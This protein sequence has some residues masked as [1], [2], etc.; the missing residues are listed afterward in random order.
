M[1]ESAHWCEDVADACISQAHHFRDIANQ[2][3]NAC[4]REVIHNLEQFVLGHESK[5]LAKYYVSSRE[6]NANTC[7]RKAAQFL[8]GMCTGRLPTAEELDALLP[9][10]PEPAS[11]DN[12][13]CST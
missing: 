2:L 9:E 4:E 11:V 1:L 6:M 7:G 10:L 13:T 3:R 5:R 12:K 8:F